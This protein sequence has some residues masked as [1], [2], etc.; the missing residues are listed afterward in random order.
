MGRLEDVERVS[1]V[2][3]SLGGMVVR[4][5][6]GRPRD[7]ANGIEFGRAVLIAPP[8]KGALMADWLQDVPAYQ[9]L[10]GPSGQEITSEGAQDLPLPSIPFAVIAG[11]KG[12]GEGY[13]PLLPGEDD[14]V[15]ALDEARLEGAADFLAVEAI[16]TFIADQPETIRAVKA[17]LATGR[18]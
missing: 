16:H 6:L 1:F 15:V 13:S 12:D 17:F 3:H 10:S 18:F 5:L 9:A 8:S 2:T 11:I 7:F 14:G 4:E